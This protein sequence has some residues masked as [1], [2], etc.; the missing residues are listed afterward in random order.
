MS[1][2][3]NRIHFKKIRFFK[4]L[5]SGCRKRIQERGLGRPKSSSIT[6]PLTSR[7]LSQDGRHITSATT[8]QPILD[9]LGDVR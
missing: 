3:L 5:L 7:G 1:S 4:Q 9:T 8:V 6:L 2:P